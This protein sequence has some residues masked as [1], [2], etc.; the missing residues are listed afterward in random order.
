MIFPHKIN[1]RIYQEK[2]FDRFFREG[3]KRFIT[4]WHRRAGKDR[5]WWN[6]L[7]STAL[8]KK[9]MYVYTFPTLTQ[10]KRAIWEGMTPEGVGFLDHIPKNLIKGRPNNSELK[11]ELINGSIIRLGGTDHYDAW[12]GTNPLGVVMSEYAI[13]NPLAWNLMR[14]ILL[15]NGGWAAF[16]YT[17][18]GHN[19]GYKLYM[20]NLDNP[21]WDITKLTIDDT[22]DENGDKLLTKND[23]EEEIKSGMSTNL[24]EQEYYCSFDA[25]LEG[26][27][28]GKQ[29]DRAYK[30]QRIK[31][32]NINRDYRVDTFWDFGMNDSTAI[33]FIQKNLDQETEDAI[34]YFESQGQPIK[35]YIDKLDEIKRTLNIVYGHHYAPHDVVNRSYQ[36][37]LSTLSYAAQLGMHFV[38]VT[39]VPHKQDAI[40]LTRSLIDKIRFHEENCSHGIECLKAYR[41]KWNSKTE[42]FEKPVHDWASH[43]CLRKGTKIKLKTGVKSIENV[44]VGDIVNIDSVAGTVIVSGYVSTTRVMKIELSDGKVLECTPDH[45]VFTIGGVICAGELKYDDVVFTSEKP[46]WSLHQF[47]DQ[48]IRKGITSYIKGLNI[49]TSPKREKLQPDYARVVSL[50]MGDTCPVYDLTIKHHHCYIANGILVSNSD[51]LMTRACAPIYAVAPT[52]VVNNAINSGDW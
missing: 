13:Q 20:D 1:L 48:G 44:V 2:V 7:I 5:T 18:R 39:R 27:L 41:K 12:V 49:D 33:W 9:G 38:K 37:G 15:E 6:I 19:H 31:L 42:D 51:A 11:I 45:K 34:Y 8:M 29:I 47:K 14:P 3:K 17:P 22:C 43:G 23:I 25:A 30:E 4:L 36:T 21:L 35:F 16:P 46:L 26:S 24:V 50:S 10:A 52:A 28:F 40:E 32:F